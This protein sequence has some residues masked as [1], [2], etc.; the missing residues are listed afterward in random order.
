MTAGVSSVVSGL[1]HAVK[2]ITVH[3][4]NNCHTSVDVVY[5]IKG[6]TS[7]LSVDRYAEENLIVSVG[8]YKPEVTNNKRLCLRYCTVEANY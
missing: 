4:D 6:S 2:F 8:K 7:F 3:T 5:D 1:D